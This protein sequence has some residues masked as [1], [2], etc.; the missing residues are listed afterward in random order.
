MLK[1][2]TN[3]ETYRKS[4]ILLVVVFIP[5]IT[6]HVVWRATFDDKNAL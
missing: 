3:V 6:Y 2:M 5:A 4:R 1:E